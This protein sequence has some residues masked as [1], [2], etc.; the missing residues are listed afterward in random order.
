MIGFWGGIG[1]RGFGEEDNILIVL[2]RFLESL[3][4]SEKVKN[5]ALT[6]WSSSSAYFLYEEFAPFNL[7]KWKTWWV[8]VNNEEIVRRGCTMKETERGFE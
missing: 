4:D 6:L 2:K 5:E 7:E 1:W 8:R 3:I